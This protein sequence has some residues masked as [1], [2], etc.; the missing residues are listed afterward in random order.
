MAKKILIG[1]VVILVIIQFFRPTKNISEE[2]SSTEISYHY[3]IPADVD[4]ILKEACNDCHTNN[5]RYPWYSNIQPVAWWLDHHVTDG[6]RRL[7]FAAFTGRPIARQNHSFEDIVETVKKSEMPLPSYTW[8]GLHPG[9]NLS[10][11]QRQV[12]IKWAE[13]Q[14]DSLKATYPPDSLILRRPPGAPQGPPPGA[15]M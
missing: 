6:K 3:T 1:L 10:D 11:E 4:L 2:M 12:I 5:T 14:M 13:V 7:N 9:A 15:S 8:L